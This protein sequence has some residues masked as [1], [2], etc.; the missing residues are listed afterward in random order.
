MGMIFTSSPN[1]TATR[2]AKLDKYLSANVLSP[3]GF[4]CN[5]MAEC[6]G[7][8]RG[9]FIEGQLHHVGRHYDLQ[10]NGR[11]FRIAVV[12]QE[13]GHGEPLVDLAHRTKMV[14][15]E[16]GLGRRFRAD[17]GHQARNPHMRGTT[18][19]LRLLVGAGLGTD[20]ES[21]FLDLSGERAHIFDAFALTNYL[22]CSAI[23]GGSKKGRSTTTMQ[24]NCARHFSAA[25]KILA[26]VVMIIQGR[27][28]RRWLNH[29]ASDVE[30]IGD[31]LERAI[32][33]GRP[34][35]LA[36]F[37]HPSVPSRDNWGINDRTPYLLNVVKPTIAAIHHEILSRNSA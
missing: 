11:S 28:V 25:I 24:R 23:V 19:V 15:E 2:I 20:Y 13:Y 1:T 8:H 6:S 14:A 21:E 12:G 9:T 35:L 31:N 32:I 5:S 27:G 16:S 17:A 7:S 22:L 26:P 36:N 29:V 34:V 30:S 10:V 37:T 18:S 33:G 4:R 3:A